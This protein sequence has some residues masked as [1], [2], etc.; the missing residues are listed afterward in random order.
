MLEKRK[1][2]EI[3]VDTP[4]VCYIVYVLCRR[5][6]EVHVS[7]GNYAYYGEDLVMYIIVKSLGYIP[8]TI[9]LY[10]NYIS[11]RKKKCICH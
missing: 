4:D 7:D 9:T 2:G 1:E 10:V 8:G 6:L 3:L 11:I 5:R